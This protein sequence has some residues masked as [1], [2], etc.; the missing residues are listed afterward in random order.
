MIDWWMSLLSCVTLL[1]CLEFPWIYI[2][3]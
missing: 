3:K 2:N 1:R